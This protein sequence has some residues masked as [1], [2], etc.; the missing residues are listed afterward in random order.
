VPSLVRAAWQDDED[1]RTVAR[2]FGTAAP[3][4]VPEPSELPGVAARPEPAPGP[5]GG[6]VP[7]MDA[8]RR[9]PGPASAPDPDAGGE[10]DPPTVPLRGWTPAPPP[11]AVPPALSDGSRIGEN[12]TAAWEQ[13]AADWRRRHGID[14]PGA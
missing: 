3:F 13:W 11:A 1:I 8:Y 2:I 12:D 6:W 9:L 14:G 4:A 10:I 5:V 7:D